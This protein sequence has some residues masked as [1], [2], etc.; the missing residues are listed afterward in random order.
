[1]E[2]LFNFYDNTTCMLM[3]PS[4]NFLKCKARDVLIDITLRRPF[5]DQD[6]H[7]QSKQQYQHVFMCFLGPVWE[8][9][10]KLVQVRPLHC[11]SSLPPPPPI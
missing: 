1:M 3:C 4:D 10:A 9:H 11:P 5:N 7:G 2:L 8:R 6:R